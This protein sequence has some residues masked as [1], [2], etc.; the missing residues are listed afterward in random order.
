MNK[1][2][3]PT[4]QTE[5]QEYYKN[6]VKKDIILRNIL[7][8]IGSV[9]I[10]TSGVL[11]LFSPTGNISYHLR[12]IIATTAIGG[13]VLIWVVILYTHLKD[14]KKE[15]KVFGIFIDKDGLHIPHREKHWKFNEIEF[16]FI[17]EDYHPL[18]GLVVVKTTKT[19]PMNIT[20]PLLKNP[21]KFW[22][23]LPNK[24]KASNTFD[25]RLIE[26]MDKFIKTLSYY[27]VKVYWRRKGCNKIEV[28][29]PEKQ[30]TLK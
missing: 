17:D 11:V 16:V 10:L 15:I 19:R 13:A 7:S 23:K 5:N 2:K 3:P 21:K 30:E 1:N 4:Y 27:G 26:D 28:M 24:D 25:V 22:S 12:E 18:L 14:K 20:Q 29:N 8:F 6:F 9:I